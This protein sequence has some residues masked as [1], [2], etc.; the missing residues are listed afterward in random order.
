MAVVK[1]IYPVKADFNR[2][3]AKGKIQKRGR[4]EV[5]WYHK[6]FAKL[7]LKCIRMV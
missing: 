5:S 3:V 2:V 7:G 4:Q 1:K 6:L